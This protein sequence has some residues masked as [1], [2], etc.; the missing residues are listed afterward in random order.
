[1]A[2]DIDGLSKKVTSGYYDPIPSRYTKKL[3][4]L[5]RKCLTVDNVKRSSASE[6]LN[7]DVFL[8]MDSP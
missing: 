7:T 1:M 3:S 5:I 8:S 2:K 6:L 4:N